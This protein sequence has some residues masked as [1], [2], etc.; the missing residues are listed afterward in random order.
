MFS[1][2]DTAPLSPKTIT[3]IAEGVKIEGK[4][5]SPGSIRIDGVL[6]GEVVSDK[7][8]II[9]KEGKVEANIKTNRAVIAGSFKGEMI[10]SGD[11]EITSTGKFIGNI[12]QKDALLTIEKGGLFK[13]ESIISER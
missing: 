4:F 3:I 12:I 9:G 11:V 1:K 10:A 7:E 8:I 5:Y 6:I 13:G 2:K